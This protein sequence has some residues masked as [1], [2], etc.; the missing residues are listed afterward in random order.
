MQSETS[1]EQR[2]QADPA[3]RRCPAARSRSF[4]AAWI[5]ALLVPAVPILAFSAT[6]ADAKRIDRQARKSAKASHKVRNIEAA[7]AEA[8]RRTIP[9][10]ARKGWGR[11]GA[12]AGRRLAPATAIPSPP[13]PAGAAAAEAE[14]AP[15]LSL[16]AMR[17]AV[18]AAPREELLRAGRHI[19]IG[20][21]NVGQL[22][23]LL[24][25]GAIGGVFLT[26]R[27]A[28][29]RTKARLAEEVAAI[30]ARA[31]AAGQAPFWVSTDQ[32]GGSVSRLSPPL[33]RQPS[34]V[35][36][37]AGLQTSEQRTSAVD[38]F[39][40]QQAQALAEVGVNLNF[41]PVADLNL[42]AR[43]AR[44]LHTRVRHR[45]ISADPE[46]VT[47]AARIYCEA[48]LATSVV[49]T[50]KHFPGLGRVMADTHLVPATL[51]TAPDVLA[52]TDWKPFRQV[53]ATTPAAVMIGHPHLA[54]A[55]AEPRPASTSRAVIEGIVR[56][57]L[58]FDGVV[59]TDDLA[60][61]AIRRRK[62]GMARAAVD[63]L[64]A[65]ADLVLLG[66]DGDHVYGVLYSVLEAMRSGEITARQ[67]ENSAARLKTLSGHA[68]R[69]G[70][71]SSQPGR[72]PHA[73]D[74]K[75]PDPGVAVQR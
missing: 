40:R 34:L 7:L 44:D 22:I 13:T 18:L 2:L 60:M 59:V 8:R 54:S 53:V 21:H 20:Y 50:L 31:E 23:P 9:K 61:G 16:A 41:A 66:L 17:E 48:L 45:S 43:A 52:A 49:C 36:L 30:R 64:A 62:G 26:T 15:G 58:G 68:A 32:E 42:E 3:P 75:T 65:G 33:P 29:G 6:E 28:R 37:L 74:L 73:L 67:L 55:D 69:P 12:V 63:A 39:A 47:E 11:A 19:I 25:R 24:E 57:D 51:K 56:R 5:A 71:V 4:G 10:R 14:K 70:T 72:T 38:R 35:R 27:N 46:I 1:G